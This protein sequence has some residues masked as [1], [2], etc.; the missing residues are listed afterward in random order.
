FCTRCDA[1]FESTICFHQHREHSD[2]HNMCTKCDLDFPTR[3]ELVGHWVTAEK[4]LHAYCRQ[5]DAHF[6]SWAEEQNHYLQ[7]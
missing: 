4:S 1:H 2:R 5:C 7:D 6:D 3:R